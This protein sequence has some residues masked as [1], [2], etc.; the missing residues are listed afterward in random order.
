MHRVENTVGMAGKEALN[1]N[2]MT[3]RA[4]SCQILFVTAC[5]DRCHK[6]QHGVPITLNK[7]ERGKLILENC[8]W[9]CLKK[10][11]LR[12]LWCLLMDTLPL[13]AIPLP[14]NWMFRSLHNAGVG[15]LACFVLLSNTCFHSFGTEK[16]TCAFQKKQAGL[17]HICLKWEDLWPL[18]PYALTPEW[19][20]S[21]PAWLVNT[22]FLTPRSFPRLKFSLVNQNKTKQ[23]A[24][25]PPT[26]KMPPKHIY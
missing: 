1:S 2:Q 10:S 17:M 11:V 3:K 25:V 15:I 8:S 22:F 9:F 16:D 6:E 18:S 19:K 7:L 24:S 4:L 23:H 26:P 5:C 21:G 13:F 12:L 14:W 20:M